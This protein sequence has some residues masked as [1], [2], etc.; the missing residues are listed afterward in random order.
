MLPPMRPYARKTCYKNKTHRDFDRLVFRCAS[1]FAGNRCQFLIDICSKNPCRNNA[2][3]NLVSQ[4][5]LYEPSQFNCTCADG[6]IGSRC[7]FSSNPCQL[8]TRNI[9]PEDYFLPGG[10]ECLDEFSCQNNA[11]CN[12]VSSNTVDQRDRLV[13]GNFTCA[14]QSDATTGKF[15]QN[16]VNPCASSP[17]LNNGNCTVVSEGTYNA[18][19]RFNCSCPEGKSNNYLIIFLA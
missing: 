12:V 9:N 3:C 11:T 5:T 4:A 15:C 7:Q 18:T 1:G 10:P 6:F 16:F 8:K 14:C 17:C 13:V 19:G 2:T